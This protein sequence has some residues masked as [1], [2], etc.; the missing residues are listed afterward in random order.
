MN[1]EQ[2]VLYYVVYM[3]VE[4]SNIIHKIKGK[5]T[6]IQAWNDPEVSR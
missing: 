2:S 4:E 3:I 5:T 6:P 1:C